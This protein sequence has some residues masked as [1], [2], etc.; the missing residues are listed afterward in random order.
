[1]EAERRA[2]S[3]IERIGQDKVPVFENSNADKKLWEMLLEFQSETTLNV[4]VIEEPDIMKAQSGSNFNTAWFSYCGLVAFFKDQ[5]NKKV[6]A[7]EAGKE[8]IELCTCIHCDNVYLRSRT[9]AEKCYYKLG[10]NQRKNTM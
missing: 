7:I 8:K 6:F 2:K 9:R 3:T 4:L 1:M 5:T 10:Q